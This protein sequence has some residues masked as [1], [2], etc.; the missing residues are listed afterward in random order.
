[1]YDSNLRFS[2]VTRKDTGVYDCEVSGNS[3][4][5]EVRVKLTALGRSP[6]LLQ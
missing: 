3:Q 6:P 2:K 4:F 5:G 1:M